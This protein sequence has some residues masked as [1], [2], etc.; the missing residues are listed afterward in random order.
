M[1]DEN[2]RSPAGEI[3]KALK[4]RVLGFGI[5]RGGGLVE[6]QNI[7]GFAHERSRERDLLPLATR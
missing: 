3:A 1:R 7:G 2:A 6:H 4:D 5:E